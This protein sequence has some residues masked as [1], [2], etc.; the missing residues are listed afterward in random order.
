MINELYALSKAMER[1]RTV[2]Q[3]WHK[4]YLELPNISTKKPCVQILIEDG[5]VVAL[6]S[7]PPEIGKQLRRYGNNQ[8]MYPG[9]NL[10]PLFRI[11]DET[12]KKK[13][14]KLTPEQINLQE[15]RSWCSNNNW[16]KKL[17]TKYNQSMQ[18][19]PDE[20]LSLLGGQCFPP[21]EAL[22]AETRRFLD[23]AKLHK[24][25][26]KHVFEMLS[27]REDTQLALSVLFYLGSPTK[28][29]KDD[30]GSLSVIFDTP[31]LCSSGISVVSSR[32]TSELNYALLK[33]EDLKN[34]DLTSLDCKD[35]FLSPYSP[36]ADDEN[37]KMPSVKLAGGFE[38]KLRTMFS[39]QPC[40]YRYSKIEDSSYPLSLDN[41]R[42]FQAALTWLGGSS[43]KKD[44]TWT[45]LEK[46]EI[47]F[48]YPSNLPDVP[49]SFTK[50]FKRPKNGETTFKTQAKLFLSEMVYTKKVGTDSH[51]KQINIFIL[52]KIDK[53]RTKIVYTRQTD[54]YE[55]EKSSEEWTIG[56]SK[57]L[58]FFPFGQPDI[59]FPLESA[60][61]LNCFWKQDGKAA[62]EKFKP[63]PQYHGMELLMEPSISA[64][65]DLHILV[66]AGITLASLLGKNSAKKKYR[67]LTK[68]DDLLKDDDPIY[69]KVKGQLALLGL[70]LYRTNIRKEDYMENYPYLY[71]QLCPLRSKKSICRSAQ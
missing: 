25:L 19:K 9:M 22:I 41:Q 60:D 26:T 71:G 64:Q 69:K 4:E 67:S 10:A 27:R 54:P 13:I 8:G 44:F 50:M 45:N 7:I 42:K 63:I 43:E 21:L 11:T 30:F 65:A 40:Q 53:G 57:N 70:L 59:P 14:S 38:T 47:M 31:S 16:P 48:V 35:A 29:S 2:T 24:E 46:G 36:P 33:A 51:A 34:C 15:V 58:P 66:Q 56:C 12:F 18:S 49:T 68:F 61:F 5:H 28:E 17:Q 52:R 1:A 55:L 20:I 39:G 6:R 62:S 37:A 23:P 32:F 3:D